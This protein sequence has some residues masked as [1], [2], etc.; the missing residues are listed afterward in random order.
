M[1][2]TEL[3]VLECV[4]LVWV[5]VSVKDTGFNCI[6]TVFTV[7]NNEYDN[8][9]CVD[10]SQSSDLN[11]T[12][13][14]ASF[15]IKNRARIC[16]IF[17]KRHHNSTF[18]P[19]I[20][21]KYTPPLSKKLHKIPFNRYITVNWISHELVCLLVHVIARQSYLQLASQWVSGYLPQ[22]HT[23][24][25]TWKQS[26]AQS[27]VCSAQK[28]LE[29]QNSGVF[30]NVNA[31]VNLIHRNISYDTLTYGFLSNLKLKP[32]NVLALYTVHCYY[33][34]YIHIAWICYSFVSVISKIGISYDKSGCL[35][36]I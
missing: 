25:Y 26:D 36:F 3:E 22:L 6:L 11:R 10:N 31:A 23:R 1:F 18:I 4:L 14:W 21:K 9:H 13:N 27:F 20:I 28:L 32:N 12:A 5:C 15:S 29:L 8:I 33:V 35:S 2:Q 19:I 30:S 7:H 34:N 17:D 16:L 24:I